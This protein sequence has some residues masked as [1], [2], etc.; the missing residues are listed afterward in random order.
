[1]NQEIIQIGLGGVNCYLGKQGDIF[2]LFDT[3]GPIVMD[4]KITNRRE[5]LEMELEKAGCTTDNLKLVVLTHGDNDHVANAKL[6]KEKYNAKIAMH[7]ADVNLVENPS[8]EKVMESFQYKSL[9]YRIVFRLI[10]KKIQKVTQKILKYYEGFKPDIFIK[11]GDSLI[12]YGFDA[13]IIHVPGHTPGSIAILTANGDLVVGDTFTNNKKPQA[14][15]NAI[16]F[17]ALDKS[18]E[19]LCSMNVKIVYPGHGKSFELN[20]FNKI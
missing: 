6:I 19:R 11:D 17:R 9:I 3:G 2:I 13:K 1:M 18:I 15:P 14:A 12:Q 7:S 4:K 20:E 10:K 8:L 5:L 16:D